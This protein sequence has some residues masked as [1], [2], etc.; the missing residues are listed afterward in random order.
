MVFERTSVNGLLEWDSD[1]LSLIKKVFMLNVLDFLRKEEQQA[2][3][4]YYAG[5]TLSIEIIKDDVLQKIYFRVK[6]KVRFLF[7]TFFINRHIWMHLQQT[8][9]EKIK[10]N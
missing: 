4:D 7:N 3:F 2:A 1:L 9:F 6:D 10:T 8:T 5:N